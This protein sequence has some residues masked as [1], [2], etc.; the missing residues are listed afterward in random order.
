MIRQLL[1]DLKSL[2]QE[3]EM[4]IYINYLFVL[5]ENSSGNLKEK[6]KPGT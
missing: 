2:Q 1:H 4:K 6:S 3:D 5:P